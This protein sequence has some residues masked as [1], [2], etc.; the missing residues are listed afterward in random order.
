M[1]ILTLLFIV[2]PLSINIQIC[3]GEID[4]SIYNNDLHAIDVN[5]F[6][7]PASW[8][9][10][11]YTY[12]NY[13][14][15]F[16]VTEFCVFN[17]LNP[18]LS[19][20]CVQNLEQLRLV[21]TNLTILPEIK[22]FQRLQSLIIDTDN[23][24]IDQHLP[25][26]I[27]QLGSLLALKLSNITYLEDLPNE[28]EY[29]TKLQSLILIGIPNFNKIP[30]EGFGKL[31]QLTELRFIDLPNLSNI[32]STINNLQSLQQLEINKTNINSLDLE[33]LYSLKSILISLNPNLI[34]LNMKNLSLVATISVTYNQ[35]LKTMT[36]ENL[37]K[38][39]ISEFYSLSSLEEISFENVLSL[40]TISIVSN[41][42]LKSI[43][44][45]NIPTIKSLILSECELTTFPESI[46]TLK[47]LQ[48][49]NMKSNK[50]SALPLTFSTDL[51]NL[52][53]LNLENNQ[54][55]GYIFQP[56][57][58]YVRELYLNDNSFTFID[59]IGKYKS[60]SILQLN[61]NQISSIPLEITGISP[62]LTRLFIEN[63]LLTDI[64]YSMVNMRS[65][66]VF[67]ARNNS[68]PLE[69]RT[70]LE[71]LFARARKAF[72]V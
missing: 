60:L 14:N 10:N 31:S 27:G 41:P 45:I 15:Y 51:P 26:E 22:N 16:R 59:G 36:L 35:Q 47:S 4:C 46:L 67:Y 68:I 30:D 58:I 25:S 42:K 19:V 66:N 34:S 63:N 48:T 24:V 50:L 44:F 1:K 72:H 52:K 29:W 18:S 21:N 71:Q 54:F 6:Y 33:S 28:I 70:A 61:K 37:P 62:T 20:Y 11:N 38:L 56:P 69:K 49:L 8:G 23:G 64:Q 55:Q 40:S 9:P 5:Q 32:P 43:S 65:L 17:D 13:D 7:I 3:N 57:L 12:V 53:I 2:Y 39:Y